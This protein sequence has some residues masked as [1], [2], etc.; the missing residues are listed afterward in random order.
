MPK[1]YL[2]YNLLDS[3]GIISSCCSIFDSTGELLI[4]SALENVNVWNIKKGNL[5]IY[6]F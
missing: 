2:R 3:F 4:T 1:T 5:V 6:S